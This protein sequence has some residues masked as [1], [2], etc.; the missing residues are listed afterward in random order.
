MENY[1]SFHTQKRNRAKTEFGKAFYKLLNH[2]YFGKK[3]DII[4]NRLKVEF[5]KKNMNRGK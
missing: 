4:R 3:L 2:A 1:I 5:L